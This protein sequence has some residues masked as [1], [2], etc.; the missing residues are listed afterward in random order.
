[1]RGGMRAWGQKVSLVK[2]KKS[3]VIERGEHIQQ[4]PFASI[5]LRRC[6]SQSAMS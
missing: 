2:I 5:K 4:C 3:N 6:R 1:M